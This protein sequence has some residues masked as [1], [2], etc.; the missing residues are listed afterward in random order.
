MDLDTLVPDGG[1]SLSRPVLGPHGRPVATFTP[2]PDLAL[3][4][5]WHG[6]RT[7]DLTRDGTQ[8]APFGQPGHALE[9]EPLNQAEKDSEHTVQKAARPHIE[10]A[11]QVRAALRPGSVAG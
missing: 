7:T 3:D 4:E 2:P 11:T 5:I 1:G 8:G 9:H 10:A 6:G